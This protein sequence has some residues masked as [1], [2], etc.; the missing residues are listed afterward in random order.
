[1]LSKV[2]VVES[3][4]SEGVFVTVMEAGHVW[5]QSHGGPDIMENL[6]PLCAV[7]I[8]MVA[9]SFSALSM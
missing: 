2:A 4:L 8:D 1:M 9:E 7:C 3:I 6:T 5:A